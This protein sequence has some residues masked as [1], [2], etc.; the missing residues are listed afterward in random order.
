MFR[1]RAQLLLAVA[2]IA[3]LCVLTGS[4]RPA[5][6]AV[7]GNAVLTWDEA[8]ANTVVKSGVF[9]NEGFIYM[10][11]V[12]SAVHQ[13]AQWTPAPASADAAV[14]EAAYDTLNNYFPAPRKPGSPDLDALRA[15][16]L[17]T[18]PD[19]PAK[20]AGVA[21][22]A[23]AASEEIAARTGDGRLTP[24]AVSSSFPTLPE[25]PGVWRLTPPAYLAPQTPW[26]ADVRPFFLRSGDQFLPAPPPSLSS[27]KWVKAFNEVKADGTGA[28]PAKAAVATFWTA[29][30]I[31]QENSV[32]RGI[33]EAR[34]LDVREAA[35]LMAIVNV[36]G[37][38]AQIAVMN[39]KYHYLFWRPV[40]AIDP[41]SAQATDGF[42]SRG[43]DDGNPK[44]IEQPGWRPLIVTP[45]HPEY[46]AAHGSLTGA[47]SEV[48]AEYLG[49]KQIDLTEQ[50]GPNLDQT[51]HF[52]TERDLQDEIVNARIW[53]GLH[54]RFSGEA[55]VRLGV[56]V[57]RYDLEQGFAL[58]HEDDED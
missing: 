45:N 24:I 9:Q 33:A 7:T 17:A 23:L 39:A 14:V 56:Q 48:W 53:G 21:I 47:M 2:T 20:A 15:A 55:G 10:A 50:G 18:I 57:A 16:S 35:R 41:A 29:N 51:R 38:D 52:A 1:Q 49:T 8:A 37:A 3:A 11:Y 42:G 28:D 54:Y 13:A 36:V 19:G 5:A 44:T 30:A 27:G 32:L 6:A 43:Y 12:A 31:L 58:R 34:A 26:I 46:P 22:G 25:G 40:T 4:T